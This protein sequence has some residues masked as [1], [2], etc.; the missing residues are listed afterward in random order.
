M[1]VISIH[2]EL[3]WE[4]GRGGAAKGQDQFQQSR[5]TS[6]L[7]HLPHVITRERKIEVTKWRIL[8][9]IH[10]SSPPRW[11]GSTVQHRKHWFSL[12]GFSYCNIE[13]GPL[14]FLY[15]LL[16]KHFIMQEVIWPTSNYKFN[17]A[18][19]NWNVSSRHMWE[20]QKSLSALCMHK[21]PQTHTRT[22]KQHIK[23]K[24]SANTAIFGH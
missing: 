3:A 4:I 20:V 24:R 10:S 16:W 11:Y 6:I 22:H 8:N 19:V 12:M 13:M 1:R 14:Y 18:N 21:L 15:W 9:G 7:P 17:T 5:Q 23:S 2:C